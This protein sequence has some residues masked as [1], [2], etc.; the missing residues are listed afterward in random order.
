MRRDTP[1]ANGWQINQMIQ[2][3]ALFIAVALYQWSKANA[4]DQPDAPATSKTVFVRAIA[5]YFN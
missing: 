2:T 3:G 4:K 1:G 5:P